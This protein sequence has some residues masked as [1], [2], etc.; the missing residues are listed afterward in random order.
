MGRPKKAE[1]TEKVEHIAHGAMPFKRSVYDIIGHN[2]SQYDTDDVEK[3]MK[4]LEKKNLADLQDHAMKV[5]IMPLATQGSERLLANLRRKFMEE[6]YKYGAGP[7]TQAV[8][9]NQKVME[10]ILSRGK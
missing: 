10:G 6:Q 7:S 2:E 5:G 8:V 1:K 4:S 9:K 3:Y